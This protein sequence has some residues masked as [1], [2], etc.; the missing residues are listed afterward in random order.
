MSRG[1]VIPKF[2]KDIKENKTLSIT[3][4]EMTR[5]N[6]TLDEGVDFVTSSLISSIG[7]EIFVW[8]FQF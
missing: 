1:S 6:I 3:H 2:L 4:P 5:F 7:G 8:V